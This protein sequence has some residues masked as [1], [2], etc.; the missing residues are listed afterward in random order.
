MNGPPAERPSQTDPGGFQAWADGQQVEVRSYEG[1]LLRVLPMAQARQLIERGLAD[2]MKHCVR[3]KLGIRW[4]PARFDRPSSR[5]DLEQMQRRDPGRYAELWRGKLD[6]HVG[7][8][9][10]GRR[11]VDTSVRVRGTQTRSSTQS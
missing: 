7:K 4:L 9:A 11:T 10:L 3:V 2:E 8:G 1:E 6:A 5:P